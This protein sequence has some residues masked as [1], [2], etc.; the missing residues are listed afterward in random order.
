M[1]GYH[2]VLVD[3]DQAPLD[4]AAGDLRGHG[5]RIATVAWDLSDISSIV[6]LGDAAR[7]SFGRADA[8][9]NN[10]GLGLNTIRTDFIQRPV[11]F[12]MST[13]SLCSAFS[14]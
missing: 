14:R 3:R 8:L 12:W 6:R 7:A 1:A 4:K 9:I 11:K 10:A 5:A 13:P 2:L